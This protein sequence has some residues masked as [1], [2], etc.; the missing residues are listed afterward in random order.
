MTQ[1][2]TECK[3]SMGSS[4]SKPWTIR[5]QTNN[6]AAASWVLPEGCV[7]VIVVRQSCTSVVRQSCTSVSCTHPSGRTHP[8]AA[9][10]IFFVP[11]FGEDPLKKLHSVLFCL[12]KKRSVQP[13]VCFLLSF[14]FRTPAVNSVSNVL[15]IFRSIDPFGFECVCVV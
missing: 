2:K 4:S 13:F 6:L 11:G 8:S 7:Q 15:F 9:I 14:F 10:C 3:S 1:N 12:I 5:K